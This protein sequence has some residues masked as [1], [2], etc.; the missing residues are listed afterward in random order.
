MDGRVADSVAS[1]PMFPWPR[2][3]VSVP[4]LG[5]MAPGGLGWS[6]PPRPWETMGASSP[7]LNLKGSKEG[8]GGVRECVVICRREGRR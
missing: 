7:I 1:W 4:Y 3:V 6:L 8:K 2:G 5:S